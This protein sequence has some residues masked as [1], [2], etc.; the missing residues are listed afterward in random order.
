LKQA[1]LAFIAS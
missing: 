1:T